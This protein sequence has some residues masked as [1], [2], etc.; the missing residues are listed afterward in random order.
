MATEYCF[1]VNGMRRTTTEK[2]SLLRYLRDDLHL[3]S[4]K[5]GCSEG[6]CGTCTIIVDGVAVKA[7]VLTTDKS[8][9]RNIVTVEGLT[10]R[11]QDAF[12]YAFGS[13]GSVQCGFCIPGMVMAGKALIDQNPDPTEEE[14]KYALRGNICRCTGYKKIIEGIQLTAAILRGDAEI[15]YDL[16]RGDQ[17]G[18]GQRAFRV[19]VRKKVLGYGK[20]PDDIVM[21]GMVHLSAVRSKYPRA[22]VLKIDASKAEALPGV[23]GVLTAK[24]VPTNKVGHIQQDWDVMI[25]EGDITRMIGDTICVVVAETE[26]ILEKAKKLVKVDYEKLEP[27]RNVHEAMAEDAPQIHSSGNLCQQRHVT[28]GDAKTALEK[29]AYKVTRSFTTPFTEHAFLEPEC[30]VSFPYKDGIKILST[31]QGAFD[32]RKEVSIMFGWDPEKIVVENQLIGGCFGGKEDVTVQHLTAL[33]AYKYQ[34]PVKAKF[35]RQES[36]FFHPKRHAMEGT[37]TLGCDENGIF[38][39]LDCE[40]YF[41]TGAYAS[42][43]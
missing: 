9:G 23:L 38:T 18:V 24:D 31:D 35:T 27:I 34:R 41:D 39:G 20:Y 12:V 15:D 42:L 10:E 14:I 19:D 8:V 3:F 29:A 40:I 7:C 22:R 1:T 25:A 16:E 43:C 6:A 36:L 21:D 2:K 30:A 5:D 17:Y 33:A 26:E 28:R 13:K 32:T 4:V 37:F 11:E